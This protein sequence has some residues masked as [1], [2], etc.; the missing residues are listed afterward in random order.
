[1]A[2]ASGAPTAIAAAAN[3]NCLRPKAGG[4]RPICGVP[5]KAAAS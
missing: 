4:S 2:A 3:S 1:M 5:L